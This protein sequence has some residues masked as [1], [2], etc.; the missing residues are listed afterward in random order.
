MAIEIY[1]PALSPTM[2]KGTLAKWLVKEGDSVASGDML[3]EIETDKATM[4]YESI[5]DGVIAKIF[6]AE[7]AEDVPVGTIIALLAEEGEDIAEVLADTSTSSTRTETSSSHAEISSVQ[8]DTVVAP[9]S[10]KPVRP[11]LVEGQKVASEGSRIIASPLARRIAEQKG[12]NL[13]AISGSGPYGRIIKADVEAVQTGVSTSSARTEVSRQEAPVSVS[14]VSYSEPSETPFVEVKLTSMRKTIARRLT[15]SKQTV[16]HFYLTIDCEI[17]KLL[18]LRKEL[19]EGAG[20]TDVKLSV[21]D[22]V[23]KAVGLAL[24]KVPDANASFAG[25]KIYKYSRA[26]ISVAVA[27]EGGLITPVVRGACTKG[28]GEISTIVKDLAGR[29]KE[30]KLAPHEYSGGTFSISNLGMFGI[31]EFS[32]VI[33]PPEGAILA[34]GSGEQR[35][36]VKDGALAVATVMTCT[37]SCDHRVIDGTIGAEFLAAFKGYLQSPI[38]MLL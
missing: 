22:F 6:I 7:G 15:E 3:C 28:L 17:D 21:N 20:D 13:S 2:E 27:I 37:L 31:K 18:A 5:D 14:V 32:A 1:M 29:A 36:V 10:E 16:P 25:D 34:I 24:K 12:L 35:P 33:N 9:A 38:T 11:E 4:E 23:I 26:D 8:S 19:N 30:G